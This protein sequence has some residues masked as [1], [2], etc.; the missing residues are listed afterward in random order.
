MNKNFKLYVSTNG[1]NPDGT[2][3]INVKNLVGTFK[4]HVY[5]I[6]ATDET[7]NGIVETIQKPIRLV[8]NVDVYVK[9][10]SKNLYIEYNGKDYV[11]VKQNRVKKPYSYLLA[12]RGL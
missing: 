12:E 3:S 9:S 8:S 4:C 10:T 7:Y 5:E 6:D 2:P 11:I 1:I